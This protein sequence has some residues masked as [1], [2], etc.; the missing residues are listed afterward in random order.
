MG[1]LSLRYITAWVKRRNLRV[2]LFPGILL[3]IGCSSQ[4]G[5][6]GDWGGV[7]AYEDSLYATTQKNGIIELDMDTGI[8][9]RSFNGADPEEGLGPIYSVPVIGDDVLYVA[10][11]D[12]TVHALDLRSPDFGGSQGRWSVDSGG[13]SETSSRIV[14]GL[15]YAEGKVIFG[16]TDGNVY[17]L[18]GKTGSLLWKY[19]TQ[20]MIWGAPTIF[21]GVCYIGSMDHNLYA[22]DLESGTEK[23]RHQASGAIVMA[24]VAVDGQLL[25]GAL[26]HQFYAV[27]RDDG[28]LNWKFSGNSNWF[29]ASP[30]VTKGVGYVASVDG[31]IYALTLRDG[32]QRWKFD[33]ESP[34]VVA[35][36]VT[37]EAVIVGSDSGKVWF[38]DRVS[39]GKAFEPGYAPMGDKVRSAMALANGVVFGATVDNQV[40]AI[41]P[42]R[43]QRRWTY[44]VTND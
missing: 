36:I 10:T 5:A 44:N 16:S 12:G 2:A 38:L 15:A 33:I 32:T 40:W 17:A 43:G 41:D 9:G 3:L 29:W 22:L 39:G 27:D 6:S 25:F 14:G 7:V 8:A 31:I 19:T 23:W 34:V 20:G 42:E 24:P 18:D 11:Y 28:S 21:D 13:L 37:D 1:R 4:F 30:V 35:P 26:D